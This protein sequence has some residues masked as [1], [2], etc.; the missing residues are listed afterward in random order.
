MTLAILVITSLV[1]IILVF[2]HLHCSIVLEILLIDSP[3]VRIELKITIVKV[4]IV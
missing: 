3:V 1:L 2:T 4:I